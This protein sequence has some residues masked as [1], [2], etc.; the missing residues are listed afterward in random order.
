[1]EK[2][3]AFKDYLCVLWINLNIILTLSSIYSYPREFEL[4]GCEPGI[5]HLQ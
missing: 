3:K 5:G 2:Y 1:M 4:F